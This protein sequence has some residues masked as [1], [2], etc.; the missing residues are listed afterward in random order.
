MIYYNYN[1]NYFPHC[2]ISKFGVTL[3]PPE[4]HNLHGIILNVIDVIL[5]IC[6]ILILLPCIAFL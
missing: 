4:L 6:K 3:K 1:Y 5:L 2:H